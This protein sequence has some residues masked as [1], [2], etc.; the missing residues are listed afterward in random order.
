MKFF[1]SRLN[2][3]YLGDVSRLVFVE[4]VTLNAGSVLE[5]EGRHPD[6]SR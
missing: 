1:A 5:G 6:C 4:E 2:H 3:L